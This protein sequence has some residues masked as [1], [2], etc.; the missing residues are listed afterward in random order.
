MLMAGD[1][2]LSGRVWRRVVDLVARGGDA[3]VYG[4]ASGLS[5]VVLCDGLAPWRAPRSVHD[6]GKTVLDLVV[7][8]ALGGDC[9][10]GVG[11]VPAL[12]GLVASDPTVSRL[13]D[14]RRAAG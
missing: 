9:L 5:K 2:L 7:A 1:I 10:A 4:Y 13:T 8:I 11:A 14:A 6:P 3:A 12:R